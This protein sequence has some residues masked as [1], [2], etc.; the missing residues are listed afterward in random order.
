MQGAPKI[1]FSWSTIVPFVPIVP[2]TLL[3][4]S[5]LAYETKPNELKTKSKWH[6]KC[7]QKA[8]GQN[9]SERVREVKCVLWVG[10]G[11][12][13]GRGWLIQPTPIVQRFH[14]VPNPHFQFPYLESGLRNQNWQ[15]LLSQFL[16]ES[17]LENDSLQPC[18]VF[19]IP[20]ASYM[21]D[22]FYHATSSLIGSNV[23]PGHVGPETGGKKEL[24]TVEIVTGIYGVN[25]KAWKRA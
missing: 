17:D 10:F 18:L 20:L 8:G 4:K 7:S 2:H 19:R 15:K 23:E 21:E 5:C 22:F 14:F 6:L 16:N 13:V 25:V 9:R 1:S 3:K 12:W 24:E 11:L